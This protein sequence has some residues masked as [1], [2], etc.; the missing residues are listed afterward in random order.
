MNTAKH[1]TLF[2]P[3]T[4]PR[5]FGCPPGQDFPAAIV[6]G[7]TPRLAGL[8]PE[9]AARVTIYVNTKRMKRR[10]VGLLH[11]ARGGFLPRVR[12]VQEIADDRSRLRSA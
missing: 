3:I 1:P 4:G 6:D 2:R 12:L 11:R 7:L 9:A 8:P 5:L 10:I